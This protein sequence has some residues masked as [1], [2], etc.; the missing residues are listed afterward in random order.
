MPDDNIAEFCRKANVKLADLS[1][2]EKGLLNDLDPPELNALIKIH[3]KGLGLQ[4]IARVGS[5]GF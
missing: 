2:A 1:D 4:P 3:K 5:S